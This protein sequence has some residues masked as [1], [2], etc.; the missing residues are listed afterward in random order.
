M[1]GRRGLRWAV[2]LCVPLWMLSGSSAWAA[3]DSAEGPGLLER[4]GNTTQ[5]VGNKIGE[6]FTKAA[7]KIEQ[8][9]IGEKVEG[10]LKKAVTKTEEGF[11]KAGR[12]IDEQ[13]H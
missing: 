6:G 4:I 8:K 11:K 7:K 5:R 2:W 12:K 13:L 1:D 9:K 3:E 10:K